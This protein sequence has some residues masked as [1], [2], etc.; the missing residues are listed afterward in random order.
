MAGPVVIIGASAAGV[1]AARTLRGEGFDGDITLVD[2]DASGAYERPPLSKAVLQD[3][4]MQSSEIALLTAEDADDLNIKTLYGKKCTHIAPDDSEIQLEGGEIL[5]YSTLVLAT[6]GAAS[7]LPVPGASLKGVHVLRD[8]QDAAN[9]RKE[10]QTAKSVAVIGGGLIGSEVVASLAGRHDNLHWIDAAP[11]PLAHILPEATCEPLIDWHLSRGVSLMTNARIEAF[12]E[13]EDG[14]SV[15]AIRFVGG[16]ELPVDAVV[17]GVGMTPDTALA[18]KAGL[19]MA[20]GGIAVNERQA[21]SRLGIYAAGDV[22]AVEGAD[23]SCARHEHWQAAEHQGMNA[24]RSILGLEPMPVPVPWFWSDQ[25]DNHLEMVGH[26]GERSAVRQIDG[27][28]PIV[29][30]FAGDKLVGAVSINNPTPVRVAQRLI[31]SGAAV[32]ESELSDPS[33]DLR[34]LMRR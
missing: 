27:E 3:E 18:E 34:K 30:E 32:S 33:V 26:K 8:F 6:G 25:A 9:L 28:W 16:V 1:S 19:D 23:G 29:F 12:V 11:K 14:V 5:S 13:A 15:R 10:L 22:A 17:L 7:R 2:A 31:K 24:A 4:N 20:G 21:T